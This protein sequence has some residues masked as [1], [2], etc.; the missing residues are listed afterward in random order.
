VRNRFTGLIYARQRCVTS[1]QD[2]SDIFN[3]DTRS[4]P[5]IDISL[6]ESI[7]DIRSNNFKTS[8]ASDIVRY[9][10]ISRHIGLPVVHYPQALALVDPS[11]SGA[12]FVS[13]HVEDDD[14]EG[15]NSH[16]GHILLRRMPNE[17]AI[18]IVTISMLLLLVYC[19][20]KN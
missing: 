17:V 4:S 1:D 20:R 10:E 16:I 13:Y 6:I 7:G 11:L 14:S 15:M 2:W 3:P 9:C 12:L 8:L 18:N 5:P 19:S